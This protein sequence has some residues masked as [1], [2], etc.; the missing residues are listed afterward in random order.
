GVGD[1]FRKIVSTIKNV[2]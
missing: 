2:V 1:I